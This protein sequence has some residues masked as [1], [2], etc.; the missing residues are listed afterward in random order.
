MVRVGTMKMTTMMT[1]IG[2][3]ESTDAQKRISVCGDL[4]M[5]LSA[6]M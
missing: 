1:T 2:N 4:I 6:T 3:E 5:V